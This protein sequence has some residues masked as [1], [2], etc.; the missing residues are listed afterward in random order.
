[1]LFTQQKSMRHSI[2]RGQRGDSETVDED[3]ILS[4]TIIAT[5]IPRHLLVVLLPLLHWEISAVNRRT[6]DPI[7]LTVSNLLHSQYSML[8]LSAGDV[9]WIVSDFTPRELQLLMAQ[10]FHIFSS[11]RVVDGT[12]IISMPHRLSFQTL[13]HT[14]LFMPARIGGSPSPAIPGRTAIKVVCVPQSS[15]A[16]GLPATTIVLD[17]TTGAVKAI[18]N[19]RRLTPL[20]NAAGQ[21]AANTCSILKLLQALCFLQ[22]SSR[23]P[24]Q[25]PS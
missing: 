22:A 11:Q 13:N 9:E 2:Y 18:V 8:I 6:G 1:M 7:K 3:N 17:E 21:T 23:L 10:V 25:N 15:D 20:R 4:K 5:T 12:P 24:S 14:A 19:A 16:N